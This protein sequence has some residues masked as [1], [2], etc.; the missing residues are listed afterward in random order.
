MSYSAHHRTWCGVPHIRVRAPHGST[1]APWPA[2][3]AL[4]HCRLHPSSP[5]VG[6]WTTAPTPIHSPGTV[7]PKQTAIRPRIAKTPWTSSQLPRHQDRW[8]LNLPCGSYRQ[9]GLKIT[10]RSSNRTD[11]H[12]HTHITHS[13]KTSA[14]LL[15]PATTSL[16]LGSA[17]PLLTGTCTNPI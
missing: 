10:A 1:Y 12:T 14:S 3:Q 4:W 17:R 7:V 13:L 9:S 15:P 8:S 11:T 2:P 5:S 16:L 6:H